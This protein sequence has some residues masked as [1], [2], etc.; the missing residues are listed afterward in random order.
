MQDIKLTLTAMEF[1]V[2][3]VWM[4]GMG[5]V[6]EGQVDKMPIIADFSHQY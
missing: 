2:I 3:L 6:E 4:T 5:K 1:K